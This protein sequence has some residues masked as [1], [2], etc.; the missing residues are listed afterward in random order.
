MHGTSDLE[1]NIALKTNVATFSLPEQRSTRLEIKLDPKGLDPIGRVANIDFIVNHIGINSRYE[2]RYSTWEGLRLQMTKNNINIFSFP[3][4]LIG[5]YK[6]EYK[7]LNFGITHDI[8]KE[9]KFKVRGLM[10]FDSEEKNILFVLY[11]TL[12]F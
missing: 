11:R 5:E 7:E 12:N 3:V 9:W 10:Y 1:K 6:D 8:T 2:I 4:S